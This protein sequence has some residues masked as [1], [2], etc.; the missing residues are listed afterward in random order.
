MNGTD[1][2][3]SLIA[4]GYKNDTELA[5]QILTAHDGNFFDFSPPI[6]RI[7]NSKTF[8]VTV[9]KAQKFLA[10]AE[11]YLENNDDYFNEVVDALAIQLSFT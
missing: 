7:D 10:I 5:K 9:E 1:I 2:L 3:S 8:E 11:D 6:A 4:F